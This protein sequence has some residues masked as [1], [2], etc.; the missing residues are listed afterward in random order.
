ML[1]NKLLFASSQTHGVSMVS[2]CVSVS[3]GF[4]TAGE[5]SKNYILQVPAT[6]MVPGKLDAFC[7]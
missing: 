3:I 4:Q 5:V 7:L 2:I 1:L 6:P